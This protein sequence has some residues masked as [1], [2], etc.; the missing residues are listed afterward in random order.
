MCRD[1]YP[2]YY[3][4]ANEMYLRWYEDDRY[5]DIMKKVDE[6]KFLLKDLTGLVDNVSIREITETLEEAEN[7]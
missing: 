4:E 7:V 2:E 3:D 5:H 1:Y 6:A